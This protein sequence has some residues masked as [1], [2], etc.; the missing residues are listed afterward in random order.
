MDNSRRK[1]RFEKKV[2][3]KENKIEK[4]NFVGGISSMA[5]LACTLSA[6][7]SV[8]AGFLSQY[9]IDKDMDSIINEVSETFEYNAFIREK[10]DNLYDKLVT[11]KISYEEFKTQY[12]SLY[13]KEAILDYCVKSKEVGLFHVVDEYEDA[14]SNVD[15]L[16]NVVTPIAAGCAAATGANVLLMNAIEKKYRGDIAKL[17]KE[18]GLL[19]TAEMCED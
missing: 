19:E 14:K 1:E 7:V 12:E 15:I 2:R 9:T 4:V 18:G 11:G 8:S 16:T 3:Q 5:A 17:Q 10:K 13:S 6:V